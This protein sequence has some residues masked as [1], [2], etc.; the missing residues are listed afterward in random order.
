MLTPVHQQL[1]LARLLVCWLWGCTLEGELARL[2][3]CA[4]RWYS[5]SVGAAWGVVSGHCTAS[6]DLQQE[7]K[8]QNKK[9]CR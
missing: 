2:L 9:T 6:L 3:C 8:T 4:N 7:A 5:C 1:L